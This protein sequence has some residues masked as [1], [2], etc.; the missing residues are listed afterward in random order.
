MVETLMMD[1]VASRGTRKVNICLHF[2]EKDRAFKIMGER[3][4]HMLW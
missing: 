1:N 4:L 3:M 2:Y